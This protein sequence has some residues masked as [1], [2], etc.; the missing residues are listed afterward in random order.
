MGKLPKFFKRFFL[1]TLFK[2]TQGLF[3]EMMVS[4]GGAYGKP[5]RK[6]SLGELS[7]GIVS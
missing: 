2:G 5:P 3:G 1:K 7:G 4:D 6:R